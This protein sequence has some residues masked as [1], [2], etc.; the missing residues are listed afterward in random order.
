MEDLGL[1]LPESAQQ[2]LERL[3]DTALVLDIGGWG[4]PF[5]RADWVLDLMPYETRGM[6]GYETHDPERFTEA[7]WIQ[8]DMCDREP[9]PFADKSIDFVICSHTL[10]DIRDPIWVCEE[11][12]R[13]GRAGYIET[14]S[15][16]EEQ[17]YGV[18]GPWVGWGHHRW[19]VEERSGGLVF[20]FKHHVICGRETDHFP[21]G[22]EAQLSPRDRV[23]TFWWNDSFQCSER[24]FIG[25]GELDR[26][27]ADFVTVELARRPLPAP[28]PVG[29]RQRFAR[30]V[31][32]PPDSR[33]RRAVLHP[34]V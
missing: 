30:L 29:W 34:E 9:F 31:L 11:M 5:P 22:F 3:D 12:Q 28:P 18:Q 19:L 4:K 7:T 33:R 8:R 17:A 21:S 6:Y 25:A 23:L 32:G 1:M 26:F 2:I 15:R 10:E 27:V 16:L 20:V 14:P 13:I 24:V